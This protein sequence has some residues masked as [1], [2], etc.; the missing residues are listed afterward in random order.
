MVPLLDAI[1]LNLLWFI[2]RK[3]TIVLIVD[4]IMLKRGPLF[5]IFEKLLYSTKDRQDNIRKNP[6]VTSV[7]I[8]TNKKFY[9]LTYL[10]LKT[11]IEPSFDIEMF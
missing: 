9:K 7:Y 4:S 10:A 3:T 5:L 8:S 2:V 6:F 1:F 11:I